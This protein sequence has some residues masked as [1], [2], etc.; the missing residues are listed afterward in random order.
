MIKP[1]RHWVRLV[2]PALALLALAAGA[3]RAQQGPVRI[4]GVVVDDLTGQP[5][6]GALIVIVGAN[7]STMA[8]RDG[9]FEFS[10]LAAGAFALEARQIGFQPVRASFELGAG[11]SA[12]ITF[13]LTALATPLEE[14]VVTGPYVHPS[15]AEFSRRRSEGHGHF[16]TR[17]DIEREQPMLL[18]D[19]FDQIPGV[20]LECK[21]G[22]QCWIDMGRS[23]P[24]MVGKPVCHVQYFVD[25]VR[26]GTAAEE[27][28]INS[29]RPEDIEGIEIYRGASSVPSRYTGRDARCGVVLIWLRIGRPRL[30][31]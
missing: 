15:M 10:G 4:T 11:E 16:I 23:Q 29:F 12:D 24:S 1:Y 14:V 28:D 21:Y 19:L 9:R 20:R 13:S 31:P 3:V 6:A 2:F 8:N 17:E 22:R 30:R 27:V 18:S 7:D 5:I 25:G 26:Y